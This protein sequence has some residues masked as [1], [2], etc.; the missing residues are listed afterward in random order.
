MREI[1]MVAS[2]ES[3]LSIDPKLTAFTLLGDHPGEIVQASI[4]AIN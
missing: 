1:L 2:F 4:F 3:D